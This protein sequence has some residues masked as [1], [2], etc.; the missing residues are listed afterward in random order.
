MPT[1]APAELV[2]L[3][4]SEDA[5]QFQRRLASIGDK[6]K[7]DGVAAISG[8]STNDPLLHAVAPAGSLSRANG[9][10]KER[11]YLPFATFSYS[12]L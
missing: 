5:N 7:E 8:E 9:Q 10:H 4:A 1:F 11:T 3:V 2:L 6:Q 12:C